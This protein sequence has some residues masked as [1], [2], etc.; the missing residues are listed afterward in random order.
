MKDYLK[1]D[2]FVLH[3]GTNDLDSDRSPDLIAKSIVNVASSLK[4]DKHDVTILN[5]IT[6]NDRFMA[7]SNAVNKSLTNFVSKEIFY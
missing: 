2:Y 1:P 7:K 3:V 5:I 4:S 6:R